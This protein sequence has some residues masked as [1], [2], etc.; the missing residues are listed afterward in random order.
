ML[1]LMP[2]R[3]R[4]G[5]GHELP[6]TCD[7]PARRNREPSHPRTV[8]GISG[9]GRAPGTTTA[10]KDNRMGLTNIEYAHYSFSP[11][12]GCAR[13]SPGCKNCFADRW[14]QRWGHNDLWR[15]H[16]P[17]QAASENYWRQP[18]RWN[19]LARQEGQRARILCGTLCDVF[20]DHPAVIEARK[21]L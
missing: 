7:R 12:R 15:R 17:R 6:P 20:E 14:A 10:Q 8:P 21:R 5:L 2:R 13:V 1:P 16:G 18:R 9:C 11:W 4:K 3:R 19:E